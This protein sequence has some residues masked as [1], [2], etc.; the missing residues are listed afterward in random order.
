M[1]KV[2]SFIEKLEDLIKK[3]STSVDKVS[4]VIK[5]IL[6]KKGKSEETIS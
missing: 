2:N 4:F 6:R 1:T 5:S 3:S